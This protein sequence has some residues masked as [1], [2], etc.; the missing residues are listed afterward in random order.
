M[1]HWFKKISIR[2]TQEKK[3]P[4]N[5]SCK[6][7][8]TEFSGNYCPECGQSVK[9]YDKPFSFIFY[10]FV[11]DFFAFDTRFFRTFRALLTKP[12][13]LTKQYFE[14][15]RVRYAPP[16]RLFIFISFLMFMLLQ[17]YTNRGLT[18]VLDS[19]LKDGKVLLDSTS[20]SFADSILSKVNA[21]M[22]SS[23]AMKN[24]MA[25]AE[26]NAIDSSGLER[27]NFKINLETFRDTRDLRQVL[28]KFA[29]KLEA[30]LEAEPDPKERAKLREYIRLCRAPEQAVTKVLEYMSW[31]FFLLLPVFALILKLVYI[32]RNQNY[33]RHLIFSIHI[34]SFIFLVITVITFLYFLSIGNIKGLSFFLGES[35]QLISTL[36]MFSVAIYFII[37]LKKFYGQSMAK[38]IVK[39]ITTSFLYNIVFI[40]VMIFVFL[41]ALSIV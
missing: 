22:D 38:V 13:F 32:R 23:L 9:D 36:L 24:E 14:G 33:M 26:G 2:K 39:F 8:E 18:E 41:N 16:F 37:A 30:D 19:D 21:E 7:C 1:K 15:K 40:A 35:M 11:G 6:N 29:L 10:N 27:L 34:H 5:L 4:T 20:L 28:N 25:L 12:G 31:A 17:I 3:A